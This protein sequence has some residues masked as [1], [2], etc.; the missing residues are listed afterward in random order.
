MYQKRDTVVSC[1]SDHPENM[2]PAKGISRIIGEW[3]ASPETLVVEKLDQVMDK[4]VSTY[5]LS[6]TVCIRF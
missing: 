5:L 6:N 3:S 4:I 2:K 1:Y